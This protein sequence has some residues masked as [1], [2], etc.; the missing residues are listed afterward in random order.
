MTP[1]SRVHPADLLFAGPHPDDDAD[2][3]GQLVV[4]IVHPD[5]RGQGL[6]Q[7]GHGAH[8]HQ[9]QQHLDHRIAP[10]R[11]TDEEAQAILRA[12]AERQ[13]DLEVVTILPDALGAAAD[14]LAENGALLEDPG[15]LVLDLAAVRAAIDI[16]AI[17]LP[18][19]AED[20]YPGD[21]SGG[22]EAG[23]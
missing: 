17:E 6:Q 3:V 5:A 11:H 9:R 4:E 21:D 13:F 10:P 22:D 7:F 23:D 16:P 19:D 20:D 14:V 12:G 8:Q 18:S 2:D 15:E 1:A